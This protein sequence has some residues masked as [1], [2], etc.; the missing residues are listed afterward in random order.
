[1]SLHDEIAKATIESVRSSLT[2]HMPT[3]P[4]RDYFLWGISKDNP[5]REDFLQMVGI[6]QIVNLSSQMI[7][8]LIEPQDRQTIAQYCG[9]INAYFL[10]EIMSDNL[11]NGLSSLCVMDENASVRQDIL[12]TF[13]R[14]M[15][16]RLK[17][18][19]D[20][21]VELL[22]PIEGLTKNISC[23]AQ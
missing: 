3:S 7:G 6:H 21:T 4:Q 18:E 14:A 22:K 19:H 17:G 1:M 9:R 11:A 23:F 15:V 10:Y 20:N 8:D 16:G 12:D 13:N 5:Y 2:R